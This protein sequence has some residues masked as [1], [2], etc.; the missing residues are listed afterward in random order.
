MR[1]RHTKRFNSVRGARCSLHP[2]LQMALLHFFF[3][4]QPLLI[5]DRLCRWCLGRFGFANG[6]GS[7]VRCV[8]L[9]A[10]NRLHLSCTCDCTQE[11]FFFSYFKIFCCTICPISIWNSLFRKT[12][13]ALKISLNPI[14]IVCIRQIFAFVSV[15]ERAIGWARMGYSMR[16]LTEQLLNFLLSFFY[17]NFNIQNI[18][19]YIK[20][21]YSKVAILNSCIM[22]NLLREIDKKI[23][24]ILF[25]KT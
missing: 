13:L 15:L 22:F 6:T 9:F 5:C 18:Q 24:F 3:D 7:I 19:S 8:L 25:P 11:R 20:K 14:G 1:G 16:L 21:D 10:T 2:C 4:S 12:N 23:N 17:R